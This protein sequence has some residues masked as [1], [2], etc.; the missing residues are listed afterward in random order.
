MFFVLGK[1]P[2]ALSK[3]RDPC[4][5]VQ[6]KTTILRLMNVWQ[7]DDS[8]VELIAEICFNFAQK[9]GIL[10]DHLSNEFCWIMWCFQFTVYSFRC[11]RI[12][13]SFNEAW[14]DILSA[15][16]YFQNQN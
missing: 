2:T 5:S 12:Q 14:N 13:C 11:N 4:V 3:Q 7:F 6:F 9:A 10:N 16:K 1:N 8:I 15:T